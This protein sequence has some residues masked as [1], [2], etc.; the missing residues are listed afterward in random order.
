MRLLRKI[1]IVL[2]ALYLLLIGGLFFA[3]ERFIFLND[4][5]PEDYR[6]DRGEEVEIEVEP[7]I[8]L[9]CLWLKEPQ[10]QGVILYLHGNKGSNRRC[11]RQASNLAG[12]GFDVFM[13]DY[14]GYGKSDGCISSEKQLLSDVEKVYAFLLDHY[15]ESRIIIVG[16]SLGSGMASWL[17]THHKPKHLVLVAPYLSL[18]DMKDRLFPFVPDAI[19]KYRLPN[20][21]YLRRV[22]SPVTIVHGTDDELIPFE[23]AETLHRLYPERVELVPVPGAGHRRVIFSNT[24][25]EV[26]ARL[27]AS[28]NASFQTAH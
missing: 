12:L 9:S 15:D 23:C 22:H 20:D 11:A 4:Q 10:A 28:A 8:R 21:E 25:R 19:L 5:L 13:P 16:Y 24:L 18:T 14:R 6:F 26:L 2:L 7:G 1:L 3:Q 27:T 17:A